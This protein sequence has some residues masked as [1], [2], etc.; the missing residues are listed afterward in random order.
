MKLFHGTSYKRGMQI[1]EDQKIKGVEV[2]RVYNKDDI[3]L[4]TTDG[5]VYLTDF[6]KAFYYANTTSIFDKDI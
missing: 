5:Y 6:S 3:S 4:P 2:E 1:L